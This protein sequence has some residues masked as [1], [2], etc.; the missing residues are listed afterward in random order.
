MGDTAAPQTP[1]GGLGVRAPGAGLLGGGSVAPQ[2]HSAIVERLRARITVCRQHHLSCQGRYERS[3]AEN[4]DREHESTLQLLSLAQHGQSTGRKSAKQSK[5][6]AILAPDCAQA[7]QPLN[8]EGG[9]LNGEQQQLR[10]AGDQRSSALIA[11]QGSLKRKLVVGLS[12]TSESPSCVADGSSL[13]IKRMRLNNNLSTEQS[14]QHANNRRNQVRVIPMGQELHTKASGITNIVHSGENDIFNMTLKDIK[15]EPGETMSCSKHLDGHI[16]QENLFSNRYDDMNEHVMDLELQELFNELTSMSESP[17]TDLELQNMINITIK[18]DEPFGVDVGQQNQRNSSRS[19]LLMEKTA[20][21]TEYSPG[22]SQTSVGSPQMRPSSAGPS[23]PM[24]NAAMSTSSPVT[25][26]PQTQASLPVSSGSN[27]PLSGWQ[28]ISHAEQL[29][30]IAANRLQHSMIQQHQQNQPSNWSTL[31]TSGPSSKSFGQEKVLSPSF[32]QQ[33]FDPQSPTLSGFPV[34]GNQPKGINNYLYKPNSNP[35]NNHIDVMMQQKAHDM[36]RGFMNNTYTLL[37]QHHSNAKAL[38]HFNSEQKK[39]TSSVLSS[40]NKPSILHYTPQQPPPSVANQQQY[41]LQP[42]QSQPLQRP[43]NLP[44]PLQ[45]KMMLQKLQQNQQVSR[46]QYPVSQ[47]QQDQ[48]CM[49]SQS[50]GPSSTPL[51]CSDPNTGSG[52]MNRSQQP[53]FNQQLMEKKQVLQKQLMEQKQQLLLQQQML[54][55]TDKIAPQDQLNRHLTRPPP[56]YKDQRRNMVSMQQANQFSGGS[57]TGSLNGSQTMTNPVSTHNILPRNPALLSTNHGPRVPSLPGV[58]NTRMYGNMSCSQIAYNV[59][60]GVNQM[61]QPNTQTQI[62][63]SQNN[64]T[65]SRQST[66]GQENSPASFG[67]E[68]TSNSKQV[69]PGQ[70]HGATNLAGQRASNVTINANAPSQNWA[71]P[72]AT[73]QDSLKPATVRFPTS[74]PYSNQ[75]IQP[76][77][78]N[79][80]FPPNQL[81]PT[82]HIR[83][84]NQV[85]QAL[86]GQTMGSSLR[87]LPARSNQLRAQTAPGMNQLGTSI[88]QSSTVPSNCFTPSNQNPRSFPGTED[89]SELGFDFLNQQSDSLG[90]G[91]NSD[92][93]FI[94]C[95]LKTGP[96]ADDWMKDINLDEI[97][98]SN[99]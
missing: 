63:S 32:R 13:D 26:V 89:S 50:T 85:N 56:E 68:S 60:L 74:S 92:S 29:K 61:Q 79:Q 83:P 9:R 41:P 90:S 88:N 53:A 28:E 39:Q 87:G 69:R 45:Q 30:Q 38:F 72:E 37:E 8:T 73:K 4:S 40:Q 12:P 95:F 3:R 27:C 20:I 10:A 19:S 11:L 91:L 24:S 23:F 1:A 76:T 44:L 97:L 48:H 64:P 96:S 6:L 70:N 16:S 57:P 58:Q 17:M 15:K 42:L 54:A 65:V 67:T 31:P 51:V 47:Q 75:S 80:H 7:K 33:Q 66:L 25:S 46:L 22:L 21:K 71:P 77:V 86:H 36:N 52:Y 84:V 99:S 14:G 34:N 82:V 94:D 5:A 55:D 43:P 18:Q 62:G 2:V 59:A 81:T 98:G 78:G 93:D 35:Q 49:G